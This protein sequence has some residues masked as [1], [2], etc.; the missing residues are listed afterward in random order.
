MKQTEPQK[1]IIATTQS[2]QEQSEKDSSIALICM[3]WASVSQPSLA[4]GLI[5]SQLA[6]AN[7]KSDVI[8][9]NLELADIIGLDTYEST[10]N[11]NVLASEWVFAKELGG[12]MSPDSYLDYLAQRG[13]SPDELKLWLN[14]RQEAD[15]FISK[16]LDIIDWSQYKIIGLTTSMMQTTSSLMFAQ[17]LKKRYPHIKCVLGGASCEGSM[18]ASIHAEFPEIDVVV[19]G[20][21]D[22]IVVDL[23]S[24]LL[25]GESLAEIP[26][27]CIRVDGKS[28]A[29]T[30]SQMVMNIEKNPTP[31]FDDYFEQIKLK[32][33]S[34][35][36]NILLMFESSRGCWWGARSHCK[37]CA[38]NGQAMT[39]RSKSVAR[40]VQE[41]SDL[42][43]RYGVNVFAAADNILDENSVSELATEFAERLPDIRVFYDI[44]A[45]LTREEMRL[46]AHGGINELE[47][48]LEN[49]SSP[50]LKR[51]GK[52][53]TGINNVRF[54][55]RCLEFGITPL[56]NYLFGFPNETLA[57]YQ[58]EADRINPWL[59]HLPAPDVAFPLSLQRYS[60]YFDNAAE[61]GIDIIGPAEDY[62]Y[63]YGLNDNVL[64]K[65][66]YYFHFNHLDGYDPMPTAQLISAVV[67]QW[68]KAYNDGA[69][70]TVRLEENLTMT[71][72]DNRDGQSKVFCC[73]EAATF[74]YRLCESPQRERNLIAILR[75]QSPAMYLRS[76][77]KLSESIEKM[78]DIGLFYEE[79]GRLLAIAKP[80]HDKFWLNTKVVAKPIRKAVHTTV[81]EW[82]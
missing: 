79:K 7:I 47:A 16:C 57:L 53:A 22:D 31:N 66:A 64:N 6:E 25:L 13:T 69:N 73:E 50:I 52:G 23:F 12:A 46:L 2:V 18:G 10:K 75:Q 30:S 15:K 67:E 81:I 55:R 70:L 1:K 5:K 32:P 65:L 77:G 11:R 9:L 44:R 42:R 35:D 36:L 37:F 20:E 3:P 26:G 49:L 4:L 56:W 28:I 61:N 59:N 62:K 76:C 71:I 40:I 43:N 74:M 34:D 82:A 48:G 80:E 27:L 41:V 63:I 33:F 29:T 21:A 45:T 60:P 51:M 72:M 39:Y 19:Q 38:L 8:Y 17:A 24:K 54:L 14:I 68:Q 78:K 58:D